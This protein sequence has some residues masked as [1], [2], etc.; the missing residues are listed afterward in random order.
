MVDNPESHPYDPHT[1]SRRQVLPFA[2][3]DWMRAGAAMT[4]T[5]DGADNLVDQ[6]VEDEALERYHRRRI[7]EIRKDERRPG[8]SYRGRSSKSSG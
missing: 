6:A 8:G 5:A 2:V 7:Q 4:V 3:E 1:C